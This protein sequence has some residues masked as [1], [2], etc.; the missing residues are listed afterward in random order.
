MWSDDEPLSKII[1]VVIFMY[2][3]E[4]L[5]FLIRTS[6]SMAQSVELKVPVELKCGDNRADLGAIDSSYMNK[7]N[8][9]ISIQ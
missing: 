4:Y 8:V 7:V 3:I 1:S 2:S 9:L 5:S 6:M